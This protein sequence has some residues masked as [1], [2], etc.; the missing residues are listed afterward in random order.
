MPLRQYGAGEIHKGDYSYY[1]HISGGKKVI[2]HPDVLYPQKAVIAEPL[3]DLRGIDAVLGYEIGKLLYLQSRHIA[4]HRKKGD[5]QRIHQ[6][7]AQAAFGHH[8]QA[9][10]AAKLHDFLLLLL[11]IVLI[12]LGYGV[13]L[14]L[15]RAGFYCEIPCGN[16]NQA[17]DRPGET[18]R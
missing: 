5:K 11:R 15:K 7:L 1:R 12:G 4:E 8:A 17:A 10:L 16:R 18:A 3:A 2:R 6:Q 14:R 9:V 13:N